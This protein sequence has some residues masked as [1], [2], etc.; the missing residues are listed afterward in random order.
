MK[1]SAKAKPRS[2]AASSSGSEMVRPSRG[3]PEE[4]RSQ[5]SQAVRPSEGE[6]TPRSERDKA[7]TYGYEKKPGKETLY[8]KCY[9]FEGES[10]PAFYKTVAGECVHMNPKCHGLR[11]RKSPI[12]QYRV[13]MYCHLEQAHNAIRLIPAGRPELRA[14]VM[15]LPSESEESLGE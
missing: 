10:P 11:N 6:P 1:E 7:G 14:G 2:S 3:D 15:E 8:T 12:Q 4:I 9:P 13:C 5:S